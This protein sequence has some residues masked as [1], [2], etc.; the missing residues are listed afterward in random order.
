MRAAPRK[1]PA[2]AVARRASPTACSAAPAILRKSAPPDASPVKLLRSRWA[3]SA[4][5]NT[6]STRSTAIFFSP[7][8]TNTMAAQLA[9][10]RSPLHSAKK[11]TPSRRCTSPISCRSACS[12]ARLAA[13]L[14]LRAPTN[15]LA[16]TSPSASPASSDFS[17][18]APEG[19][20]FLPGGFSSIVLDELPFA[21]GQGVIQ[22]LDKLIRVYE[23]SRPFLPRLQ[24]LLLLHL[25]QR[26]VFVQRFLHGRGR[27]FQHLH[28]LPYVIQIGERAVSGDHLHVRRQHCAGLLHRR[29][30]PLHAAAACDVDKRKSIT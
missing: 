11:K 13:A 19:A 8:S 22:R 20:G 30:H 15:T 18:L 17:P 6:A 10:E 3:S 28:E 29:N 4:W 14:P 23:A 21:S 16:A 2:A 27:L 12:T 24:D 5:M 1:S 9:S 7:F 26:F 25:F